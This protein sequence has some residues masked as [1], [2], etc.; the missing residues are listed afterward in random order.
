MGVCFGY[1][2]LAT[3]SVRQSMYF[4]PAPSIIWVRGS[5]LAL[6]KRRGLYSSGF[7]SF[8]SWMG[9]MRVSSVTAMPPPGS[10]S[11]GW[12]GVVVSG[13]GLGV[14]GLS[15]SCDTS[16]PPPTT[17]SSTAAIIPIQCFMMV[18]NLL[19]WFA[20]KAI[21]WEVV[22]V[23]VYKYIACKCTVRVSLVLTCFLY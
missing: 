18:F 23:S 2:T 7:T 4:C 17:S 13:V 11:V 15:V 22:A 19:N 12:V 8:V 14:L 6:K 9:T 10:S 21:N 3:K 20:N 16:Q 5:N 1:L